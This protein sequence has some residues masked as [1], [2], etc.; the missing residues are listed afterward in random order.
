MLRRLTI[1]LIATTVAVAATT[2]AYGVSP[3]E[4]RCTD[5]IATHIA[6]GITNVTTYSVSC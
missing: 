4:P 6:D 1:P 3:G 2:A 5:R